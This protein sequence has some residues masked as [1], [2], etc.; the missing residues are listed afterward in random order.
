MHIQNYFFQNGV[1]N[2]LSKHDK[3]ILTKF[4]LTK[5]FEMSFRWTNNLNYNFLISSL[6]QC[7]ILSTT[8]NSIHKKT[9]WLKT[10]FWKLPSHLDLHLTQVKELAVYVL[11]TALA[12][13]ARHV[14]LNKVFVCA[15]I[16]LNKHE[17]YLTILQECVIL[18]KLHH[19]HKRN[20]REFIGTVVCRDP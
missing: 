15:I 14:Y 9:F 16:I 5:I 6:V 13:L 11:N 12:T 3:Y 19:K 20:G 8:K 2:I 10:A 4:N 1:Y 7:Y 17:C 18:T